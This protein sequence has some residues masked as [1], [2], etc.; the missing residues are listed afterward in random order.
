MLRIIEEVI[1][2][3]SFSLFMAFRKPEIFTITMSNYNVSNSNDLDSKTIRYC[4]KI[5]LVRLI[6]HKYVI[7]K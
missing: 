4:I 2:F 5:F 7:Y 6:Y 1:I 3:V